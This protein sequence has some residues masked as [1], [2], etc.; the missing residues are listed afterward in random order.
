M[1]FRMSKLAVAYLRVS[2]ATNQ[3]GHGFDRQRQAIDEFAD[4]GRFQLQKIF[5]EVWTGT[6]AERPALTEMLIFMEQE[7]VG[8]IIIESSDRLAR[9]LMVQFQLLGHLRNK[10]VSVWNAS[11][12]DDMTDC[13]APGVDPV[14][15]AMVQVQA[16][17]S[18]LEKC[19]LVTKLRKARD[20]RSRAVGRR[21]E[22]RPGIVWDD[23]VTNLAKRLRR[24]CKG[25]KR[26]LRHV[27]LKLN[28]AG[29]RRPCG[30][31]IRPHSV[32]SMLGMDQRSRN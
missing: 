12:G 29:H 4:A 15:K 23:E 27:A 22:G 7:S 19:R 32:R 16:V 20:A 21:C 13:M 24:A 6:E 8:H 26:S 10:G 14:K 3:D 1:W 30:G 25:R 31:D 2:T 5:Q 18:E 11:T 28:E 9:D 17:F